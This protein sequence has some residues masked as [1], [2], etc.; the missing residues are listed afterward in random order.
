MQ[1]YLLNKEIIENILSS[2]IGIGISEIGKSSWQ[3]QSA[4]QNNVASRIEYPI[5]Q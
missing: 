1:V 4:G 2:E 3:W 5:I